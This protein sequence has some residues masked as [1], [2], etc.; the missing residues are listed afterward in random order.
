MSFVKAPFPFALHTISHQQASRFFS[1]LHWA[2]PWAFG[3]GMC[4][5]LILRFFSLFAQFKTATKSN[6]N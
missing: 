6:D 3:D 2:S 1:L 4:R 5:L